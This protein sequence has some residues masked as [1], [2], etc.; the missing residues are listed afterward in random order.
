L[1]ELAAVYANF[2]DG[3]ETPDLRAARSLLDGAPTTEARGA[4]RGAG[5]VKRRQA[6]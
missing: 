6:P 5:V 1:Q 2:T 3:T 4:L